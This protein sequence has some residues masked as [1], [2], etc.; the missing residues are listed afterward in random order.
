[1]P[2]FLIEMSN[3]NV[4]CQT[5]KALDILVLRTDSFSG[6]FNLC[7]TVFNGIMS[8]ND[9]AVNGF[10]AMMNAADCN[11]LGA[12]FG[13]SILGLFD[14]TAAEFTSFNTLF[15]AIIWIPN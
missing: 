9:L 1:M 7:G 6:F 10:T 11:A 2:T 14:F 4:N 12:G 13:T 8:Q 3:L 5:T 15:S